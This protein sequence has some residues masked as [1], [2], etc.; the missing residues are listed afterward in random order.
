MDSLITTIVNFF[1][2]GLAD[3]VKEMLRAFASLITETLLAPFK[4]AT[5][6]DLTKWFAG[7]ST[8]MDTMIVIGIALVIIICG[9]AALMQIMS[10]RGTEDTSLSIAARTI[11]AGWL[12]LSSNTVIATVL[13]Y[14]DALYQLIFTSEDMINFSDVIGGL[15][16]QTP[17]EIA[18]QITVA[19]SA[20]FSTIFIGSVFVIILVIILLWN[21][22]KVWFQLFSR[23]ANFCV[24]LYLCPCTLCTLTSTSTQFVFWSYVRTMVTQLALMILNAWFIRVFCVNIAG[25]FIAAATDASSSILLVFMMQIGYLKVVQNAEQMLQNWGLTSMSSGKMM[26]DI[27]EIMS[28]YRA[29]AQMMTGRIPG[30]GGGSN[31]GGKFGAGGLIGLKAKAGQFIGNVPGAIKAAPGRASAA[32]KNFGNGMKATANSVAKSVRGNNSAVKTAAQGIK[33]AGKGVASTAMS[34]AKGAGIGG[35]IAGP[36]GVVGGGIIGGAGHVFSA[37]SAKG[38]KAVA[39]EMRSATPSKSQ[40]VGTATGMQTAMRTIAGLDKSGKTSYP[41]SKIPNCMDVKESQAIPFDSNKDME[42][43]AKGVFGDNVV[44]AAKAGGMGKLTGGS[45]NPDTGKGSLTFEKEGTDGSVTRNVVS[46]YSLNGDKNYSVAEKLGKEEEGITSLAHSRSEDG[47]EFVCYHDHVPKAFE[48]QETEYK[49]DSREYVPNEKAQNQLNA[50]VA[51]A[52]AAY[53]ENPDNIWRFVERTSE[54]SVQP[55]REV[56]NVGSAA[57]EVL[58][59]WAKATGHK[60]DGSPKDLVDAYTDFLREHDYI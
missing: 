8:Y 6:Q 35:I 23:Y 22:M 42:L 13:K 28:N 39:S 56:G 16:D 32:V 55:T 30:F 5:P 45:Y 9:W 43:Q 15:L 58:K 20:F 40:V 11:I 59:D 17:E 12:V 57:Y 33:A 25:G 18:D 46:C 19:Q 54:N 51:E 60:T 34:V 49:K 21:F 1:S 36:A 26:G 41:H 14:G 2:E 52:N 3:G 27:P 10:P 44:N 37:I 7:L 29:A 4:F 38:A 48:Q 31:S 24:Q 47:K 53:A 50:A